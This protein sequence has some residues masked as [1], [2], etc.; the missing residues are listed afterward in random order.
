MRL[1]ALLFSAATLTNST[2]DA[3]AAAA[4]TPGCGAGHAE[5]RQFD[6]WLGTWNVYNP[7]GEPAG[8]SHIELISDGCGISEHWEGAKGSRG[9]SYN[10]WDAASGNWRQ[11]WVGNSSGD[12]LYLTGG[13][14]QGSMVMEGTRPNPASGQPQ[15]QRITW[16]PHSDGNVRQLWETSDDDGA[17]WAVAFDGEYRRT[18]R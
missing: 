9:V 8:R 3:N 15:R 14:H 13:L 2:N 10:A 1:T 11:F 5:H 18:P 6:F 12:V 17:T 16:T 7:K 4:P